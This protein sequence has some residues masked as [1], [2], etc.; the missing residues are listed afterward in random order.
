MNKCILI[1][2]CVFLLSVFHLSFAQDDFEKWKEEQEA[3]VASMAEAEVKYL[4]SVTNEYDVYVEEQKRLF[5]NFKTEVEKK[6]DEF[7]SSTS[8]MFVDYDGDLNARSSIDFEKGVIEIEVIIDDVPE[9]TADQKHKE[10]ISALEKKIQ[11]LINQE[12]DDKKPLLKDQI[13][14]RSGQSVTPQKA[15]TYAR[16]IVEEQKIDQKRIKAKDNSPRIK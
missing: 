11:K 8:K 7:K 4:E 12:S 2:S 15:K 3:E 13:K 14:T 16:E 6:W 5:E 10:G 9:K 1:S